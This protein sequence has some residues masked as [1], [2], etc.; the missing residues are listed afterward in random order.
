MGI[1]SDNWDS[2]SIILVLV[3][4]AAK[5]RAKQV[6][7]LNERSEVRTVGKGRSQAKGAQTGD[8]TSRPTH[9]SAKRGGLFSLN[10]LFGRKPQPPL[11][12]REDAKN[13]GP[14]A[15][16]QGYSCL[17]LRKISPSYLLISF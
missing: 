8:T 16:R 17:L 12:Y 14:G 6:L 1:L 3:R 2:L 5:T 11:R 15:I 7:R 4:S 13:Q 9:G 10:L